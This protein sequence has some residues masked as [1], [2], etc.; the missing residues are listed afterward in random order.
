MN[1]LISIFETV[2][3]LVT[4]PLAALPGSLAY[5]IGETGG[6]LVFW[7][8]PGRRRIALEN[9]EKS[10]ALGAL[11]AGRTARDLALGYFGHMGR[12]F[13]EIL[14]IYH[15]RTDHACDVVRV[16][17]EEHYLKA[18]AGKR[19]LIM[20]TGHCGNWELLGLAMA[21]RYS[22]RY[23]V[24]A[25]AQNNPFLERIVDKIRAAGGNNIIYKQGAVR[26]ILTELKHG[27]MIGILID[28]AVLVKEG[29]AVDFLGRPAMTTKLPALIARKTGAPVL[30][31]F[32]HREDRGG[33]AIVFHPE[34]ELSRTENKETAVVEDMQKM[35]GFIED[36][37]LA[38]P[39][40]WLW[41]HRRW[42]RAPE[43]IFPPA[44]SS[45]DPTGAGAQEQENHGPQQEKHGR[46]NVRQGG[47]YNQSFR[48]D[49]PGQ[50]PHRQNGPGGDQGQK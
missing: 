33:H 34:V 30:P 12:S 47:N 46:G 26:R 11:P 1:I 19:G 10:L 25:R 3:R 37:I 18:R 28:Q 29:C 50:V 21:R 40:Q 8:W 24:V 9:I 15:G 6:R 32:I 41:G 31:V 49:E 39:E 42:K 35:T 13:I 27:G 14:K 43:R 48:K 22:T 4:W 44:G 5:K 17:G 36:Y 2:V 16:E 7:L 23:S 38:H 20:I 45:T